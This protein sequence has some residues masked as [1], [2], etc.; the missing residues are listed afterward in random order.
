MKEQKLMCGDRS[1]LKEKANRTREAYKALQEIDPAEYERCA[2]LGSYVLMRVEEGL[3]DKAL[4]FAAQIEALFVHYALRAVK[5]EANARLATAQKP[6]G[7]L[8]D[9]LSV[10]AEAEEAALK[11]GEKPAYRLPIPLVDRIAH[12]VRKV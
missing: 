2:G 10:I 8:K 11:A 9:V 7:A 6:L 3:K 12:I 1:R 4:G 5:A